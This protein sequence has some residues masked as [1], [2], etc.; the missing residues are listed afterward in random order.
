[1][2]PGGHVLIEGFRLA[3]TDLLTEIG[4]KR[5]LFSRYPEYGLSP[6]LLQGELAPTY[7]E[8]WREG[9]LLYEKVAD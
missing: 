9:I 5:R 4:G 8:R 3:T 1:M 6:D 2:K 7:R